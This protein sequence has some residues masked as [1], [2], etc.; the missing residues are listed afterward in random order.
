MNQ[1]QKPQEVISPAEMKF[2]QE[3]ADKAAGIIRKESAALLDKHETRVSHYKYG[4]VAVGAALGAATFTGYVPGKWKW[5]SGIASAGALALS[6]VMF[7]APSITDAGKRLYSEYAKMI[8]ENP[9]M[10]K[11]LANYYSS[12]I[13]ADMVQEL[14]IDKAVALKTVEYGKRCT[15]FFQMQELM[16]G[17]GQ[18][19]Q[20]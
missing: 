16:A 5:A 7:T 15:T 20:R 10:R 2:W 4:T 3:Q 12:T 1:P 13:S 6:A 14:G 17:S 18:G 9:E 19:R 11:Q 8:D